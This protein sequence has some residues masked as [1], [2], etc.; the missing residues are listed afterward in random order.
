VDPVSWDDYAAALFD[1]D[2]V[3]TPTAEVHMRAWSEMFNGFL[4]DEAADLEGDR[5]PYTDA[6]YYAHVDGKPRYD[7][8]RDFLSSRGIVIPEGTSED[9][10]TSVTVRGLGNR[11]NDAFN[12]VLERDGVEA[13]PGSVLLLDHLRDLGTPLA[14]VS[15]SANAPAVLEAAG[16]AD[17]FAT[18]VEGRVADEQGLKGK[19]APE[20]FVH[21]AEVLGVPV[22]RAVVL[23]D[24]VS[25]VRAGAAGGF[26][27]VV[28]VDRGAGEATLSDA[29]AD[30]VVSDLGELVPGG[31]G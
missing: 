2:G 21:A 1:L 24:A 17:R 14:V 12:A 9:P 26:A 13:Y 20:T 23:E 7:G 25:G 4:E 15:S 19:P 10:P 8:V 3:I 5:A 30:V 6:D 22:A 31:A 11:K 18:V 16:L 27:L 29:G 28:G